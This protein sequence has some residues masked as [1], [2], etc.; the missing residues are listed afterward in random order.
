MS[1]NARLVLIAT[2][3]L[4]FIPCLHAQNASVLG[5]VVSS[6]GQPMAG[7]TVVIEN[8]GVG[9]VRSVGT[10]GDAS[11]PTTPGPGGGNLHAARKGALGTARIG[12][13]KLRH[14]H[15]RRDGQAC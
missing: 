15:Q 10:G 5:T 2:A 9:F 3:I 13:I 14:T 7:V 6:S 8:P 4:F 1:R 12:R 11:C